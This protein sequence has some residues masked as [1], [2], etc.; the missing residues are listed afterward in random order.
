MSTINIKIS[1]PADDNALKALSEFFGSFAGRMQLTVTPD[2]PAQPAPLAAAATGQAPAPAP[3]PAPATQ[4]PAA[5]PIDNMTLN[6][7]VKAAQ[8]RGVGKEAILAV[9]SRYGIAASRECP[10][11][12]RP[13]LLDDLKALRPEYMPE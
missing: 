1:L 7:E 6:A 12:R 11:D 13:A 10:E 8:T 2:A 4:A 3:A 9:F 5:P